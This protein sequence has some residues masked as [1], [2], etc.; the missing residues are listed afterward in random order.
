MARIKKHDHPNCDGGECVH[1]GE[2]G[3]MY[4]PDGKDRYWDHNYSE[5]DFHACVL[6]CGTQRQHIRAHPYDD[7]WN[8]VDKWFEHMFPERFDETQLKAGITGED[9]RFSK[10]MGFKIALWNWLGEHHGKA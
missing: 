8:H 5:V 6:E 2:V 7:Y 4:G 3:R 1:I 10:Q 9:N